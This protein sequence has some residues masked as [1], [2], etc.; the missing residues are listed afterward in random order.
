[1]ESTWRPS[2]PVG[3]F[4]LRGAV[5]YVFVLILLRLS[6]KREIGQMGA[7]EFVSILLVSNAVQNSMN[8][9]AN[10]IT[11]GLILAFVI[12]SL[13]TL[14]GYLSYRSNLA[15][16]VLE[17]CPTLLIHRGELV[18]PNLRRERINEED[19]QTM[20]RKE[21]IFRASNVFQAVL[22][23]DGH[24]SV[25]SQSEVESSE[26]ESPNDLTTTLNS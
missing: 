2:L 9:G 11:G 21:G 26:N 1:M 17:G 5:V 7:T 6:G 23:S 24:L 4:V 8:G 12:L 13:T 3:E 20:L 14:G 18:W 15:S 16:R 22:E 10:S 25:I 19:L